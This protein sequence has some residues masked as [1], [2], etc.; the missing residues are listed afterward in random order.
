M[1]RGG[2]GRYPFPGNPDPS[3][4]ISVSRIE[5]SRNQVN[6]N[7][8]YSELEAAA[9]DA[10]RLR[11]HRDLQR[12]ENRRNFDMALLFLGSMV[13]IVLGSFIYAGWAKD[14]SL[15]P[16]VIKNVFVFLGGGGI[17]TLISRRD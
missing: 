4:G 14:E 17:G 12:E 11:A 1:T 2:R 3:G 10:A 15:P 8:S 7:S 6:G 9:V 16:E 13:V 5:T